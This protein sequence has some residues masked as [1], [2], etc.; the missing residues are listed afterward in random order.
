MV[1][2]TLAYVLEHWQLASF[3]E[4]SYVINTAREHGDLQGMISLSQVHKK[5]PFLLDISYWEYGLHMTIAPLIPP[6]EEGLSLCGP[7]QDFA[8]RAF[9]C[10]SQG[11]GKSK[12]LTFR[13]TVI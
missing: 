5:A 4:S 11:S 10:K 13:C 8:V 6:D 7:P 12:K 1:P 3:Q 2:M 9:H